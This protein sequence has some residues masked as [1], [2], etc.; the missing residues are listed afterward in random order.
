MSSAIPL[1][2]LNV[3]VLGSFNYCG[4]GET[5]SSLQVVLRVSYNN[6]QADEFSFLDF[7]LGSKWGRFWAQ[8]S[9]KWELTCHY[10]SRFLYQYDFVF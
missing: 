4:R 7:V 1:G 10:L 3:S 9:R 2:R 5:Y 8:L 6:S